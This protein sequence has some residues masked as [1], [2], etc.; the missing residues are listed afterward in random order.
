MVF[1][2]HTVRRI[3]RSM[4]LQVTFYNL[5][6]FPGLFSCY[7]LVAIAGFVSVA[8][9]CIIYGTHSEYKVRGVF[10]DL[11]HHLIYFEY[12]RKTWAPTC[13]NLYGVTMTCSRLRSGH[14]TLEKGV[15][16][17]KMSLFPV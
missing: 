9:A 16:V 11:F 6:T 3:K 17:I 14:M 4:C 12:F 8:L 2:L 13:I 10:K 1:E 7:C 5:C 15:L